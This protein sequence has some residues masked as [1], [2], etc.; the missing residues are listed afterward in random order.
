MIEDRKQNLNLSQSRRKSG[1][2]KPPAATKNPPPKPRPADATPAASDA[3]IPA[4]D[5][6]IG[7]S[8]ATDD[9]GLDD[10]LEAAIASGKLVSFSDAQRFK[11]N[12]LARQRALEFEVAAGNLVDRGAATKVFFEK[13]RQFRDAWMN[14]PARVATL[15]ASDLGVEDRKL[16]EVLT[17]Y[18]RQHLTELGEPAAPD[19]PQPDQRS[20]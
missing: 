10:E 19:F 18:V 8:D 12:Y 17:K 9:D 3:T 11:E 15:L 20:S 6:T 2:A 4:A 7:S 14:W 16:V 13:A 5:A 1:K